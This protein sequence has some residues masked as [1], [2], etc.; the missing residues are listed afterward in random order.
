MP[1][2]L[3]QNS[4]T[5][6]L[7]SFSRH[8]WPKWQ[9]I[10]IQ[11]KRKQLHCHIRIVT[12]RVNRLMMKGHT[13]IKKAWMFNRTANHYYVIFIIITIMYDSMQYIYAP[14]TVCIAHVLFLYIYIQQSPAWSI[15]TTVRND[16]WISNF[17]W[18]HGG[19]M[20][21]NRK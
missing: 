19:L 8:V 9:K 20:N 14:R 6:Y 2:N 15:P 5:H 11:S 3:K 10:W 17:Q 1:Q 4:N 18:L 16:E 21:R 12:C 7:H 13:R